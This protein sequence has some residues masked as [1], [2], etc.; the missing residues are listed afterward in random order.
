MT[1]RFA[2]PSDQTLKALRVAMTEAKRL[3]NS[4]IG[5]EHLLLGPI[6]DDQGAVAKAVS[7]E[8]LPRKSCGRQLSLP[9]HIFLALIPGLRPKVRWRLSLP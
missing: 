5:P 2:N 4:Y 7:H 1:N 6:A 3:R 8:G 9:L